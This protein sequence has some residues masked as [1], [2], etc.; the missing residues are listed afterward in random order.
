MQERA[1]LFRRTG[2]FIFVIGAMSRFV[3]LGSRTTPDDSVVVMTYECGSV[4]KPLE[5]A[6][7]HAVY[8]LCDGAYTMVNLFGTV[9]FVACLA[10]FAMALRLRKPKLKQ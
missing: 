3:P 4:H 9:S 2:F 6:F 10:C 1:R 5:T 7:Q 8:G